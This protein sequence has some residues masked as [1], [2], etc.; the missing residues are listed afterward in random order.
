MYCHELRC[1]AWQCIKSTY[2]RHFFH[3]WIAWTAQWKT[4]CD[5]GSLRQTPQLQSTRIFCL[6]SSSH[7]QYRRL[8]I[9]C[10][11]GW[12]WQILRIWDKQA[13]LSS[14]G[15]ANNGAHDYI[16][17]LGAFEIQFDFSMLFGVTCTI[18]ATM[19][20]LF[21]CKY[22]TAYNCRGDWF[23]GKTTFQQSIHFYRIGLTYFS[24]LHTG[25]ISKNSGNRA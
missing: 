22:H 6:R 14:Q 5:I 15:E 20:M 12:L 3:N 25:C 9:C 4:T 18:I 10:Y 11:F 19:H 16:N 21:F 24:L 8:S 2:K 1:T 13:F 7:W 23:K 17:H